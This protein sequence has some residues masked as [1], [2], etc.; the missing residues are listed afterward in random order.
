[1]FRTHMTEA[2]IERG[3]AIYNATT[4]MGRIK[5]SGELASTILF[6]VSKGASYIT[7]QVIPI[8]GGRSAQ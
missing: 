1:M 4:P 8:D 6:L 2:I 7:G 5:Q 3:E